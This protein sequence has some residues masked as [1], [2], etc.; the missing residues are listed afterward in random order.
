MSK[1]SQVFSLDAYEYETV[2][3]CYYVTSSGGWTPGYAG[4]FYRSNG[5]PGDPPED[6]EFCVDSIHVEDDEGNEIDPDTLPFVYE[7]LE[8]EADTCR[9][10]VFDGYYDDLE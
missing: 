10:D 7:W 6:G 9:E 3:N 5:D 8:N 4:S 1:Y 2:G